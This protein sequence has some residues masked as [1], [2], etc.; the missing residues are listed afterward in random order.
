MNAVG[1]NHKP[2][3]IFLCHNLSIGGG[4]P[5]GINIVRTLAELLPNHSFIVSVPNN[6]LFHD[7]LSSLPNLTLIQPRS[8]SFFWRIFYE[9]ITLRYLS[10]R[11]RASSIIAL[12]NFSLFFPFTRQYLLL[13]N[14]YYVYPLKYI[15]NFLPL[16][17]WPGLCAQ[18]IYFRLQIPFITAF[19]CQTSIMSTRFQHCYRPKQP[20]YLLPNAISYHHLGPVT[21]LTLF[22]VSSYRFH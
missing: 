22:P 6:S 5:V 12:G 14:P 4:I 7:S 8:S 3:H 18:L 13:H 17:F 2:T 21:K 9:N 19:F 15:F 11:V 1:S 20:V 16:R 10:L